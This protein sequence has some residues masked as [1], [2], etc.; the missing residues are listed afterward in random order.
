M[1][2]LLDKVIEIS[3]E[4]GGFLKN[5]QSKIRESEIEY[6]GRSNDMVSR[7]D[8]EAE[9]KFVNFFPGLLPHSGLL[10]KKEQAR[11]WVKPTTGLSIRLTAPQ[12]TFMVSL[13]I[14]Q[15]LPCS[16]TGNL[17]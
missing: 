12:I 11:K 2:D 3:R 7:A 8:K 14:A 1:S 9:Q 4:V 15:A 16:E 13:A 10:L 6:K 17:F 5:E